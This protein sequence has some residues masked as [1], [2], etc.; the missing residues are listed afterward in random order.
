ML[1]PAESC[2]KKTGARNP[3]IS[4]IAEIIATGEEHIKWKMGMSRARFLSGIVLPGSE[5]ATNQCN[6]CHSST[7]CLPFWKG[8]SKKGHRVV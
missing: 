7:L 2:V 3:A 8:G 4:V 5:P 1:C 6:W